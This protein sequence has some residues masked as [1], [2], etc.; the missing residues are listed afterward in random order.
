MGSLTWTHFYY[1]NDGIDL[2]YIYIKLFYDRSRSDLQSVTLVE[3]EIKLPKLAKS[4]SHTTQT[5]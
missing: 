1:K 4:I 3:S 2:G 5:P